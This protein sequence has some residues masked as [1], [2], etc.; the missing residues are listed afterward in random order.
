MGLFAML[1]WTGVVKLGY[2]WGEL[3]NMTL[4]AGGLF[5]LLGSACAGR[6]WRRTE[7]R[8]AISR[9]LLAG[10]ALGVAVFVVSSI[11]ANKS[12]LELAETANWV[13]HTH[14]VLARIQKVNSDLITVQTAIGGF[15]I[16]GRQDFLAPYGA[17]SRQLQDNEQI[18]RR[19]TADNPR[20][21]RRLTSLEDLIRQRLAYC[22]DTLKVQRQG[23]FAAAAAFISKGGGL[24]I[25]KRFEAVIAAMERDEGDLLT[26]RE[27]QAR[28]Q[29]GRTFFIL[30]GGTFISLALLLTVLFFLNSE[31]TE[32]RAA[33]VTSRLGAEIVRSAS[34]AVITKT[35]KGIIT[36][37]NPGAERIFGYSAE[38][39]VG[40]PVLMFVPAE[41][42]DD[43]TEMMTK[44]GRGARVDHFETLRLRKDGCRM[45]V[46][47]TVAPLKDD[48]GRIVGGVKILRDISERKQSEETLRAS[49]ERF[50]TMANLIPQLAWIARADGLVY[51]YN[52]RWYEYTGTTPEQMEGSGWQMVHDPALLPKVMLRWT[53][54]IN[55]GEPFEMEFPL[56]GGDGKFRAFLTRVHPLKDAAGRVVQ[57]LAETGC[58]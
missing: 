49:E 52:E 29:T 56:L 10:F 30:S 2:G 9:R 35:L 19:L 7:L 25:M 40:R 16:T 22:E 43:E 47:V 13:Q 32:R 3:T 33:E 41:C 4:H 14:D 23:G 20:Q 58:G 28:A 37:W 36:S 26:R 50:R 24:E 39:A 51:W 18:L 31:A 38:E 57:W 53:D 27:A 12:A 5:M 17:A 54:A 44:N 42:A 55:S 15:V 46:S 48:S 34:D 1:G 45:H 6:A 21:Q 8:L 11:M